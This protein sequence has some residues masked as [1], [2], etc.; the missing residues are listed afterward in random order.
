MRKHIFIAML[1]LMAI[2]ACT[3]SEKKSPSGKTVTTRSAPYELLIVG[4]KE[5]LN[6]TNGMVFMENI[7]PEIEGL[8]Q[9]EPCFKS[10]SIN[11]YAFKKDYRAF[12]NIIVFE[13]DKK[14]PK[15]EMRTAYDVY[16]HPQTIMYLT[17]PDGRAMA[18]LAEDQGFHIV[19]VF[20]NSELKRE[21]SYLTKKHS[22]TVLNQVKKQF[23][24]SIFVPEDINAVKT[25]NDFMWASS[26]NEDNRLNICV[27][28]YPFTADEDF[29]LQRFIAH[30]DT[31]MQRNIRGEEFDQYMSMNK[32]YVYSC[33]ITC[34]GHFVHEVRGLWRMENDM[35]GGPFVSYTQ[36]DTLTNRVIVTEGFVF[37]PD[38]KKRP[39]IREL[40]AAL[41][42]LKIEGKQ[43]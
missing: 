13:I 43:K 24:C 41:Q 7:N 17:A 2:T 12:A 27:Y 36:V 5:W 6:T 29:S 40:E 38:K 19:N 22:T 11:T 8:P 15:A 25:G 34:D 16:A 26:N 18:D 1:M 14:Y 23:G 31:F 30:R 33:N 10:L 28:T 42:T 32:D 35:M 37:A 9:S 4:D 20:V 39:Y 3:T 21:R